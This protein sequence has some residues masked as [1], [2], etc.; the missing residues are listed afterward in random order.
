M[1]RFRVSVFFFFFFFKVKVDPAWDGSQGL[2]DPWQDK[3]WYFDAKERFWS[4][5]FG[6]SCDGCYQA[7]N[8]LDIS[9]LFGA[10]VVDNALRCQSS[11]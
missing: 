9:I 6:K 5:L 4:G 8:F 2:V 11:R 7:L 3:T 1:V 10:V